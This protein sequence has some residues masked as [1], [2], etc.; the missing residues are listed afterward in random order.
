MVAEGTKCAAAGRFDL[1]Y[2]VLDKA[3]EASDR[4]LARHLIA[5]YGET[6]SGR[7]QVRAAAAA[8][9][10]SGR[11]KPAE[12]AQSCGVRLTATYQQSAV[13]C[14]SYLHERRNMTLNLLS[15]RAT[16]KP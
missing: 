7:K 15:F 13:C 1:I 4:T 6:P 14:G 16:G 8:G 10:F 9:T 12:R 3:D 2:L 11:R 5:M